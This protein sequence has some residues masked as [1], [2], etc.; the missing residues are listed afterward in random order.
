MNTATQIETEIDLTLTQAVRDS[1]GYFCIPAVDLKI[2]LS[3]GMMAI[4]RCT[5]TSI[6]RRF[7]DICLDVTHNRCKMKNERFRRDAILTA[8]RYTAKE[9]F[10]GGVVDATGQWQTPDEI[11]VW[12]SYNARSIRRRS[13]KSSGRMGQA[14]GAQGRKQSR[15]RSTE[16]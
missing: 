14:I 11:R 16:I 10:A 2:Q 9:C 8:K 3:P 4:L 12:L 13:N 6:P 1:R 5:A 15:C 7:R